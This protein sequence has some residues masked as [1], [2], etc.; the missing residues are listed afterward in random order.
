MFNKGIHNDKWNNGGMN[1]RAIPKVEIC[2][3]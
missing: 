2:K 3:I 1:I